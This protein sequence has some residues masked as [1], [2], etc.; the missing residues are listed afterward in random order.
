MRR[1]ALRHRDGAK[2]PIG[3]VLDLYGVHYVPN[4]AGWQP[5]LCPIHDESRP[6]C[7]VNL[8]D[9]YFTCH[10]CPAHGDVWDLV[11]LKESCDFREA[12]QRVAAIT[13]E[14]AA[15]T[16]AGAAISGPGYLPRYRRSGGGTHARTVR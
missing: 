2:P 16:P 8:D 12:Q 4:H 5:I 7:T 11:M 13:G 9:C 10:A 15:T 3:P 6:S 1:D 14:T